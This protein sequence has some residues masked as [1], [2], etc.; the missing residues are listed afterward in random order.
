MS[1]RSFIQQIGTGRQNYRG[2]FFPWL[3]PQAP[4]GLDWHPLRGWFRRPLFGPQDT[5]HESEMNHERDLSSFDPAASPFDSGPVRGLDAWNEAMRE[6]RPFAELGHLP[7]GDLFTEMSSGASGAIGEGLSGG[8]SWAP[9]ENEWSGGGGPSDISVS[10]ALGFSGD[11]EGVSGGLV[12][13]YTT[14]RIGVRI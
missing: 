6:F 13:D 2:G 9:T 7:H 4:A 10:N 1:F 11:L 8:G 14:Y 12:R 5:F 3:A